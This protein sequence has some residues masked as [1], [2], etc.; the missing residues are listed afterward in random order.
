[1]SDY[2]DRMA[3]YVDVAARIAEFREK[4]PGGSL[5]AEVER[6]P[7]EDLPFV[8]VRAAAYRSPDDPAPGIGWAW[9]PYPGTTP[10]TKNSELQNAETSAWGRAIVAALAADTRKGIASADEVRNRSESPAT[11]QRTRTRSAGESDPGLSPLLSPGSSPATA[12]D[13]SGAAGKDVTGE[14]PSKPAACAHEWQPAP[15]K[16]FLL[17]GKCGHAIKEGEKP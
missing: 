16:G 10:Y 5:Q 11:P 6:W 13:Q 4:H 7:T 1:M 2:K 3:D 12:G 17:C 9:E 15:R 8:A 14:G